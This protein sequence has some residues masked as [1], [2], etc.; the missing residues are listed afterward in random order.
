MSHVNLLIERHSSPEKFLYVAH[1]QDGSC[2]WFLV[3]ADVG[4]IVGAT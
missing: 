2:P 3:G 1:L 4:A